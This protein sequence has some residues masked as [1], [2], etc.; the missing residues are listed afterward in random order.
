MSGINNIFKVVDTVKTVNKVL[1]AVDTAN[2]A[3]NAGTT[4]LKTADT[5]NKAA[6]IV[7]GDALK[8]NAKIL[9]AANQDKS[10][11]SV[12]P[13]MVVAEGDK[14]KYTTSAGKKVETEVA[15]FTVGN[16]RD[17]IEMGNIDG[18]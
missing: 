11:V 6:T 16:F 17:A 10:L 8:D 12:V 13:D 9:D 18:L 14:V 15:N 3:L 1:T 5:L 7:K 4:V 2:D